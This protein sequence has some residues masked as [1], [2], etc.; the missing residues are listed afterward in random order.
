MPISLTI[1]VCNSSAFSHWIE[2]Q[3]IH[4][5]D[6]GSCL[7]CQHKAELIKLRFAYNIKEC[8]LKKTILSTSLGSPNI[9]TNE[10]SIASW[11]STLE[12]MAA[13][14]FMTVQTF[15]LVINLNQVFVSREF[16]KCESSGLVIVTSIPA[17]SSIVVIL[18][19]IAPC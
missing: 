16:F 3:E 2:G 5:S 1:N 15:R 7:E 6:S 17:I 14:K 13:A 18:L 4:L 12:A 8:K 11:F 19:V 10:A 9:P